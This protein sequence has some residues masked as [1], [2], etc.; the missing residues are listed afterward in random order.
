MRQLDL[1]I[2]VVDD[3]ALMREAVLAILDSAEGLE[4]VGEA[5]SAATALAQTAALEPDLVLLDLRLPDVEGLGCLDALRRLH[6][7]TKVLIF[8]AVDD[9]E[10]VATALARGAEGYVLKRIDPL[11]LPAAIR[12]TVERSVFNQQSLPVEA[13][14][15]GLSAKELTVLEHLALGQSNRE[16]ASQLWVSDQTVKFHLRNVYRK[17]G[18]STRTEAIRI[19]HERALVAAAA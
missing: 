10:L 16:I 4:V 11:D 17:L 13:P 6:P 8:S 7:Q 12:Q 19:A 15:G 9:A 5:D 18:A 2:L 3:H 14:A 1:K